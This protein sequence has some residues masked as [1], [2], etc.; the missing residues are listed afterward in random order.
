MSGTHLLL[1]E[2]EA[3][4]ALT[5]QDRLMAEGYRVTH[6]DDG[7]KGFQLAQTRGDLD[8]IILDLMLPGKNGFDLCR[9]LRSLGNSLPIL[10]LTA[11]DQVLDKV[12]GL[13]LG[14]DDYLT[15]PFDTN[16]LL[17]RIEALLRRVNPTANKNEEGISRFHFGEITVDLAQATVTKGGQPVALSARLFQLL[18]YFLKHPRVLLTRDRLLDAVWG[19]EAEVA[20][21]T[22]DVHVAWLR[23]ALE[24]DTAR[25][26]H[27]VTVYGLGYKFLP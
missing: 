20:T 14:A 17:A 27:F 9:D 15:K 11:R 16:E 24:Q 5:L 4:I 6:V 13:K 23:R 25:P 10:M 7:E 3:A 21:R 1:I 26:K 12:L 18:V 8:L 19:Y 22:V 2:D